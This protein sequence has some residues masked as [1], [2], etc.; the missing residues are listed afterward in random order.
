MDDEDSI[1][2]VMQETLH[3][4]G[5]EV[6]LAKDGHTALDLYEEAL[7]LGKPF[8]VVILDLTVPGGMG[9]QETLA[10]LMDLNPAI[11]AIVSSGYAN[12]PVIA[13]YERYGFRGVVYKPYKINELTEVIQELMGRK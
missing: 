9:G 13:E 11:K 1:R 8:D 4:L 5:F 2:E 3:F 7:K 12:D 10:Y 6:A